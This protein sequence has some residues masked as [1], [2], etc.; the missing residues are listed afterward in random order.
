[1]AVSF[2]APGKPLPHQGQ[3]LH[4]LEDSAKVG[5]I[6]GRHLDS[7]DSTKPD[8]AAAYVVLQNTVFEQRPQDGLA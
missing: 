8:V 4:A 5:D 3:I 2:S 6:V 1:M 7:V